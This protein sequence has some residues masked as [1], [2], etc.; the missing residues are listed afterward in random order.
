MKHKRT[1]NYFISALL[2]ISLLL[3]CTPVT[4]SA[5][6][7]NAVNTISHGRIA[8]ENTIVYSSDYSHDEL[9]ITRMTA[10][11]A[12][13]NTALGGGH[14]VKG[15]RLT[16]TDNVVLDDGSVRIS[17]AEKGIVLDMNGHSITSAASEPVFIISDSSYVVILGDG[18]FKST[19][20]HGIGIRLGSGGKL[21]IDSGTFAFGGGALEIGDTWENIP[22]KLTINGG[23]FKNTAIT[24]SG[25]STLN[26]TV[27]NGTLGNI[28]LDT[29]EYIDE[30][31]DDPHRFASP[32]KIVINGGSVK[33]IAN[34]EYPVQGKLYLKG[35][36][37]KGST[38]IDSAVI[39]GGV[40]KGHL[41]GGN[42]SI[43]GGT[44]NDFVWATG[45]LVMKAGKISSAGSY[46]LIVSGSGTMTGGKV[47]ASADGANG[48]CVRDGAVF[49]F[50]GGYIIGNG[51]GKAG[52]YE[53]KYDYGKYPSVVFKSDELSGGTYSSGA[54]KG[55][56]YGLYRDEKQAGAVIKPYTRLSA[57]EQQDA[58]FYSGQS[59][60]GNVRGDIVMKHTAVK[61]K[62]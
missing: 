26:L 61:T 57:K 46:G 8:E 32:H 59:L 15:S 36:T 11:A 33:S 41:Y 5:K 50:K 22:V 40:M 3:G 39:T 10:T 25:C 27:N 34:G 1:V 38:E 54:V 53:E 30:S 23:V 35:G 44:I 52:I 9:W 45:K 20:E 29:A 48:V 14:K 21:R 62:N 56:Q 6:E 51:S 28:V 60:P 58:S 55:F 31:C 47:Y 19:D 43:S 7:T 24:G 13:L 37:V 42:I 4:A 16:L 2:V 18:R 17:G 12:E 49:N